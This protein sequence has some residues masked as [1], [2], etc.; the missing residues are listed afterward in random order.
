MGLRIEW[1]LIFIIIAIVSSTFIFK[2][3]YTAHDKNTSLKELEFIDTTFIEV[4]QKGLLGYAFCNYG[5]RENSI[6]YLDNIVYHNNVINS[7]LA[8]KGK[9]IDDMLYLD[10]NVIL[11]EK[12]GYI[13]KTEHLEYNQKN[14]ILNI[15]S[16]FIAIRGKN[17]MKGDTFLYNMHLKEVFGTNINTTFYTSEK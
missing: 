11:E 6:L 8:K 13:Y 9:Y 3:E 4:N 16:P 15:T 17:I 5:T 7:L 12:D 1:V 10:G 14:K 2:V